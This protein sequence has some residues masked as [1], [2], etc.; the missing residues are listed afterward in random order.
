TASL[1]SGCG[2]CT[3]MACC[4]G[5]TPS[6]TMAQVKK[7]LRSNRLGYRADRCGE[8]N[9]ER[10]NRLVPVESLKRRIGVAPFDRQAPFGG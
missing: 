8:V 10:G 3:L 1:C 5:V 7:A 6:V 2:V 4:Q 9:P